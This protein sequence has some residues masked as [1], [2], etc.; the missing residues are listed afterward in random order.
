MNP[1]SLPLS[2]KPYTLRSTPYTLYAPER[3]KHLERNDWRV[4]Y[5]AFT[6]VKAHVEVQ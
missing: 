3:S 5:L 1:T 2:P 6:P 4:T